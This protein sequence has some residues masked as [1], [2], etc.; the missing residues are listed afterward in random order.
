VPHRAE[1]APFVLASGTSPMSDRIVAVDLADGDIVTTFTSHPGCT[2]SY[3]AAH[4]DDLL[5]VTT[6]RCP[7][8]LDDRA[9][10][11]DT[12]AGTSSLLRNDT[13]TLV[14]IDRNR[15]E[16]FVAAPGGGGW[17]HD[18]RGGA[19]SANTGTEMTTRPAFDR[20]GDLLWASTSTT[21][22]YQDAMLREYDRSTG[23]FDTLYGAT[24]SRIAPDPTR[25]SPS[26]RYVYFGRWDLNP[27]QFLPDVFHRYDRQT[28]T[29]EGVPLVRAPGNYQRISGHGISPD[30]RTGWVAFLPGNDCEDYELH[31]I[32]LT[33][34]TDTDVYVVGGAC[35]DELA[36][37]STGEVVIPDSA[38]DLYV[39]NPR[40]EKFRVLPTGLD[41]IAN[42][43]ITDELGCFEEDDADC[44]GIEDDRDNCRYDYNPDQRDL[45]GDGLGDVCD[46]DDDDDGE[47][48]DDDNCPEVPNPQQDD[49]DG[50]RVGNACDNCP[51]VRNPFQGPAFGVEVGFCVDE[52]MLFDA[53]FAGL[54]E[55]LV[56]D[57]GL[58]GP[59]EDALG[60]PGDCDPLTETWL[61]EGR[62]AAHW[63]LEH[64][65]DGEHFGY[66]DALAVMTTDSGIAEST[67]NERL[68]TLEGWK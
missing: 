42:I 35:V 8:P 50:D 64:W 51:F 18:L 41:G 12:Y 31:R 49:V 6:Q 5:M 14:S 28:Q 11:W 61:T 22:P 9:D 48:D 40:T 39:F 56:F 46:P 43:D 58:D 26:E 67:A 16:V 44:D 19:V 59:W 47:P 36:V 13:G 32:D 25:L 2:F 68:E 30:G 17:I 53:R 63:Y 34:M 21:W 20:N 15:D 54:A 57:Y 7:A 62:D 1:A 27:N 29:L 38:G 3:H 45:D 60:C 55:V 33:T 23:S 66:D 37:A 52:R 4:P 24:P 65:W 10:V